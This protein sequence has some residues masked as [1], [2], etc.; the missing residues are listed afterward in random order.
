MADIVIYIHGVVGRTTGNHLKDYR[1][2]RKG[3][4]RGGVQMPEL[5][6]SITVE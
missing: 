4:L 6:D 5:N 2:I 1:A 3:L